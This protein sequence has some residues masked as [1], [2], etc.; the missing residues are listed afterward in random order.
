MHCLRARTRMG[1]ELDQIDPLRSVKY[2]H[3]FTISVDSRIPSNF[4]T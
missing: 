1:I 3:S 4:K 2:T